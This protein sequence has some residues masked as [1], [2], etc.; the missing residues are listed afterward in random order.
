MEFDNKKV[1]RGR[2]LKPIAVIAAY[3][4]EENIKEVVLASKK[5]VDE[6]LVIDDG[7]TDGTF[8]QVSRICTVLR[9][10]KNRGKGY[11]I[12]KGFNYAL[13]NKYDLVVA[14]DG[15]GEHDPK[16]ISKM[17]EMTKKGY[18]FVSAF[19][20]RKRS[21]E[22]GFLNWFTNKWINIVVKANIHDSLSGFSCLRSEVIRKI[23]LNEDGFG[24]ETELILETAFNGFKMCEIKV[25]TPKFSPSKLSRRDYIKINKVFDNWVLS[26]YKKLKISRLRKVLVCSS[27]RLGLGLTNF[28]DG[29]SNFDSK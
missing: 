22:R 15:D 28:L 26:N 29:V 7:S 13:K 12:R 17:I 3:N 23:K 25:N 14:L 8:K 20:A 4:E 21:L 6:V 2:K 24:I 10:G 27:A 5:Y 19:R 16:N 18:D 9:N 11:S 1:L